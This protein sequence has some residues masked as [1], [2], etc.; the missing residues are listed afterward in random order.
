[1]IIYF[2]GTG[3]SRYLSMVL[4]ELLDDE[5]VDSSSYMKKG[6]AGDF[7]SNKPYI[8]V[9]PAYAWRMP[10]IFEKFIR[11]SEF[12]GNSYAYFIMNCGGDNGN[13]VSYIRKLCSDKKFE[14]MGMK[15]IIMPDNYV[16][17]YSIIQPENERKTIESANNVLLKASDIIKVRKVFDDHTISLVDK[18]KSGPVNE[19]FFKYMVKSK[20]F[21]ATDACISCGLCEKNCPLGNIELVNGKPEWKERCTHCMACISCCPKTAIEYGSFTKGRR[22]YFMSKERAKEYIRQSRGEIDREIFAK[23]K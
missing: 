3:N 17:L 23:K 9:C 11:K 7:Y 6:A 1:M 12:L 14:F 15:T 22:R 18:I 8:F 5:A 16:A 4:S 21:H 2:T 19:L 10:H 20:K 13:A